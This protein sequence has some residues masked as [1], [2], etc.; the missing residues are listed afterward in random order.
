MR[1][2]FCLTILL[3]SFSIS[4]KKRDSAGEG[5]AWKDA[6][7]IQEYHEPYPVSDIPAQNEVRSIAVDD[8]SNVWIAT[9]SGAFKKENGSKN[10]TSLLSDADNGPTYSI[11][12]DKKSGIWIGAWNGLYRFANNKTE[13]TSGPDG[14][15]SAVCAFP[16]QWDPKLGIHV[17]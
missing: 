10:W 8:Q 15:I 17:T 11:A 5:S 4:C 9:A 7:F 1:I 16:A 13:K 14:P 12:V 6:S 3:F 2:T